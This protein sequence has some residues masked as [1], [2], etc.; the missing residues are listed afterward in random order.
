MKQE[1]EWT[2]NAKEISFYEEG[3]WCQVKRLTLDTNRK[4]G[5]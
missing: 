1:K 2:N 4:V 5:R 3:I